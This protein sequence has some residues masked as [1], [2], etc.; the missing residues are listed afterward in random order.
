[1]TEYSSTL[2]PSTVLGRQLGDELRRFRELA[3]LS[4]AAAAETLDCTKGKISR[5]EN[6]RVPVRVPDLVAL[7]YAYGIDEPG[8]LERLTTLARTANRRRRDGWWNQYGQVLADTYRDYIA[9]EAMSDSIR[10]FQCQLVPGLLQTPAYV[11]AVTLASKAWRSVDEIEQF[12]QVRLARQERLTSEPRL[13][14]WAVV[15][16]GVLRQQVGGSKVM[17]IQLQ[18]LATMAEEPNIT[19]QVLPFSRGA[20]AGMFG[21]YL[22]LSFPQVSALDVVRAEN[23]TGAVWLERESE[24]GRYREL[25]DDARKTALSPTESM[26]LIRRVAKEHSQ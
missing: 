23:P 22:L 15:T 13:T 19:V 17:S 4:T 5:I 16:E 20:H 6:G 10:T 2:R 12:V 14:M 18:H 7:L 24:V 11:R 8:V 21:P 1:M 9:L 3:G 26:T 25:F